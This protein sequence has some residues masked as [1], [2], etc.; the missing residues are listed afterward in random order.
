[1]SN[2]EVFILHCSVNASVRQS[3]QIAFEDY[4]LP[5]SVIDT[6]K[7]A[8][9]MSIRPNLSGALKK[10][11]D[12]LRILQKYL[13][14]YCTISHGDVHFLH[15][16]HFE[17]AMHRIHE[18]R[19]KAADFNSSL[20]DLWSEELEKW[21][22]TID[23]FFSPL[24][25]DQQELAMVREA[26]M[27]IFPTAQE[28]SSPINVCVVGP[29]PAS[30]E[31]VDDPNDLA[32]QIQEQAAI[33]TSEVLKAAKDGALDTSLAK[34]AQLVDDLDVRPASKID[35]KVVSDN[36]KRRGSWQTTHCHLALAAK[37]CPSLN[38]ITSLLEDLIRVGETLRDAPKGI[39]R[40]NAFKRYSE[41]RQEIRDEA[42][43]I[44]KGKDSSKGFEALQ[45]SLTLSNSYETLLQAIPNC[46][47][48]DDLQ[49]LETEIEAQ[50]GV[51]NHRA[52][53]LS[54]VFGKTKELLVGASFMDSIAEEL[55][56]TK[57]KSTE[58]CDF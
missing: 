24:F 50:T 39:E 26:Y 57:I 11:L 22:A 19:A 30:L 44:V 18:I 53:H 21:R 33:N 46:K 2:P 40:L 23:D 37:H 1:M 45:M 51:Y 47:S 8:N 29:Y 52:K 14:Q 28:F 49:A 34:V 12:E 9:A 32:S 41:I 48:L 20:K 58:D 35:R 43:A 27:K 6:L 42:T 13:Y 16:D 10:H 36:P 3:V 54:R 7:R 4:K 31:R 25:Q 55:K 38:G 56:E 17:D 5:P 15:P